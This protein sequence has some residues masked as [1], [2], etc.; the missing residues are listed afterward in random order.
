MQ[1]EAS[2]NGGF[3]TQSNITFIANRSDHAAE[4][5]CQASNHELHGVVYKSINL[6]V[7]CKIFSYCILST[8]LFT[9]LTKFTFFSYSELDCSR[10]HP[11]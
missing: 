3:I 1:V 5:M 4:Y 7:A 6:D 11:S 9:N 8:I 10:I 2:D